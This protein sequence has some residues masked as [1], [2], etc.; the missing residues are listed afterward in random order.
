VE[1][2][3]QALLAEVLLVVVVVVVVVQAEAL[4]AALSFP[5]RVCYLKQPT[6]QP[7]PARPWRKRFRQL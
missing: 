3:S 7:M 5:A 2:L 6:R 4:K 1:E